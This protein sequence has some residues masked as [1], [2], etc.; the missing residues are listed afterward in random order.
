MQGLRVA[1]TLAVSSCKGGV[2]KSSVS[3]R[4]A[5][6]LRD[7]GLRVGLLDADIH[8]PSLPSFVSPLPQLLSE[9]GFGSGLERKGS[10]L[11]PVQALGL[12]CM[13]WGFLSSE[14]THCR[15]KA[16]VLRG[17]W[18][19]RVVV[20]LALGTQWDAAG[21]LDVLVMDLPPGTGDVQMALL[22]SLPL[23]AAV[24]VSTPS[25]LATADVEKGL[26]MLARA[27]VP[28]LAVVENFA[29]QDGG[30]T[31]DEV[32]AALRQWLPVMPDEAAAAARSLLPQ[33]EQL[34]LPVVRTERESPFGSSALPRLLQLAR[35]SSSKCAGFRLPLTEEMAAMGA[36]PKTTTT[37]PSRSGG[38]DSS[39][40]ERVFRA[41][42][43][44]VGAELSLLPSVDKQCNTLPTGDP[45]IKE[46]ESWPRFLSRIKQLHYA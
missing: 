29:W 32:A 12:E 28:L 8:G 31:C 16:T 35:G 3:L 6:A 19:A 17:R 27:G 38:R 10:R 33:L 7:R 30:V 46:F 39:Q 41:L 26:E 13:S 44:H 14:R 43:E 45:S 2:G 20:Q 36:E 11:R 9:P 21:P 42:A 24:V 25:P 15:G 18:S 37:P 40:S 4:L 22:N 23:S 5:L 34:C 1:H